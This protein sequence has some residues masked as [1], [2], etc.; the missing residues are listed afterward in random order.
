MIIITEKN[1]ILGSREAILSNI[2]MIP[3]WFYFHIVKSITW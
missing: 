1:C 3:V 2:A